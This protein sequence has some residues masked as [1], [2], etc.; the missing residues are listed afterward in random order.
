MGDFQ[1]QLL[2]F[3]RKIFGWVNLWQAKI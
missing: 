2:Y 3:W 1:R